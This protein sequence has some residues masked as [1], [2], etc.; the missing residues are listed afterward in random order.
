[1]DLT[2]F[3]ASPIGDLVP[4]NGHDARFNRSYAYHAYVPHPLPST[5]DLTPSTLVIMSEADR[6]LG[7]LNARVQFLPNPGLLVRPALATEAKATSAIEGTYATLDEILTAEYIDG[8]IS[9]ELREVRNYIAAAYQAL[10]MIGELPL[11]RRLIEPLHAVLVKGTRGDG[12]D[13]GS[14]RQRQVFVGEENAPVEEARFVPAPNGRVLEGGFSDWERWVNSDDVSIPLLAR[15]AMAHYQFETLH[16]FSDGNGRLG[17]LIITLQLIAANELAYP[18]LNLSA[19]F[20]PKKKEYIDALRDVSLTGDFDTWVRVFCTAVKERAEIAVAT[21]NR[22]F[23]YRD[24]VVAQAVE[25][26][27]RRIGVE[28]GDF[29]IGH[30]VFSINEMHT[31]IG[32]SINTAARRVA[33]LEQMGIVREVTGSSYGR[34]YFA[35]NVARILENPS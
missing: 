1:M 18:V 25:S 4:I 27:N 12:Y 28:V 21:V 17:R 5:V 24:A 10:A 22:L 15:V 23:E 20:E 9:G 3:G 7:H 13:A 6:A 31:A 8:P 26:G 19:W 2:A 16:P 14:I 11:S 35:G 30:P 34:L 29:L 32:V 33:E